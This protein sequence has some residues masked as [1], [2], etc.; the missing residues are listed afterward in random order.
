MIERPPKAENWKLGEEYT[1]Y[2]KTH[3]ALGASGVK[4]RIIG[5][6]SGRIHHLLSQL[7]AKVFRLLEWSD[8][9][10]VI[11]EQ[12]ALDPEMTL[13]IAEAKGVKHPTNPNT[14]RTSVMTTDFLVTKRGGLHEAVAVKATSDLRKSRTLEKLEIEQEFWRGRG[15]P[16]RIVTEKELPKALCDNLDWVFS[17]PDLSVGPETQKALEKELGLRVTKG[18]RLVE[19]CVETDRCLRLEAGTSLN[20]FRHQIANKRWHTEMKR[21]IRPEEV[22]KIWTS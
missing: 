18:T 2:L 4:S 5:R 17:A 19:A 10:E 16:W 15:V 1:P 13:K 14:G 8:V 11:S 21:A 20:F 3:Q 9:V 22:L 12:H 7:E 6:K